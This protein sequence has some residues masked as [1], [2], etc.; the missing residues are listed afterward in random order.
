LR[1]EAKDN[2]YIIIDNTE[3]TKEEGFQKVKEVL[4]VIEVN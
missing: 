1:N 3:L 2:D 4:K